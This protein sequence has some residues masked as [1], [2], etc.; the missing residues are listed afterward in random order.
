MPTVKSKLKEAL[1]E[2]LNNASVQLRK[3]PNDPIAQKY[4]DSVKRLVDICE[5][6]NRY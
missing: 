4:Y 1:Y 3:N 2:E 5:A 6:R